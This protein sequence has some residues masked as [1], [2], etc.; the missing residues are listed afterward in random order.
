MTDLHCI[1]LYYGEEE[2]SSGQRADL[3]VAVVRRRRRERGS[4]LPIVAAPPPPLA[5]ARSNGLAHERTDGTATATAEGNS[6][7]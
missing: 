1:A 6:Q 7:V 5:R 4:A 3:Y 2:F